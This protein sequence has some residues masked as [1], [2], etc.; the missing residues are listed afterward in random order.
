M[1]IQA[2]CQW[3][4]KK[5]V[6]WV[7]SKLAATSRQNIPPT[8]RRLAGRTSRLLWSFALPCWRCSQ[9]FN[10][11][12]Q[13][14]SQNLFYQSEYSTLQ[15]STMV[16]SWTR[17]SRSIGHGF[18]CHCQVCRFAGQSSYIL[19]E[20]IMLPMKVNFRPTLYH[21]KDYSLHWRS[22]EGVHSLR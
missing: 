5:W 4:F 12:Q 2:K 18:K 22:V 20:A 13:P 10:N 6:I 14:Q 8:F 3:H 16:T 9:T 11:M 17:E 15:K 1:M 7:M 19:S 21:R